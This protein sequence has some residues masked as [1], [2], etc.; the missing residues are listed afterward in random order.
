MTGVPA[1]TQMK[2]QRLLG[3]MQDCFKKGAKV[4]FTARFED[5]PE[6]DLW[7]GDDT[8]QGVADLLQRRARAA[9]GITA[10][11]EEPLKK[12]T[13]ENKKLREFIA[14]LPKASEC[15]PFL[16]SIDESAKTD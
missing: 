12:L 5:N 6:A 13:E 8:F 14:G 10:P 11:R 7:M 1:P 15:A 2:L 9:L 3:Q 16:A 4:C